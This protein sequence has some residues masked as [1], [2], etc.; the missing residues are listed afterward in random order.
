ME[1]VDLA[2]EP[3]IVAVIADKSKPV[4]Y[5]RIIVVTSLLVCLCRVQP[6]PETNSLLKL[7]GIN[8]YRSFN[9][10]DSKH[11][12]PIRD[13]QPTAV[14]GFT[15]KTCCVHSFWLSQSARAAAAAIDVR[16]LESCLTPP[17]Q[18]P[19]Q[20]PYKFF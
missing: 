13:K 17:P 12:G 18:V 6:A 14:R 9:S 10:F 2:L 1:C 16:S 11:L 7:L 15:V 8:I 4:H 5:R 3:I 20:R 19:L